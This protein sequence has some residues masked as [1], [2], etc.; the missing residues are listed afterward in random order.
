MRLKC[1]AFGAAILLTI[2]FR[3][4]L[5][6]ATSANA[7]FTTAFIVKG[8]TFS[9]FEVLN[10]VSNHDLPAG[11]D[12]QHWLSLQKTE[13]PSDVYVVNNSWKPVNFDGN[14]SVATTGWHTHPGHSLIVV[15]AGTLT[16]YEGEDCERH[17]YTAGD[18]LVDPGDGHVHILRNEGNVAASTVAVQIVPSDPGKANRRIDAPAP[19]SCAYI[20]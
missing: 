19:L 9:P 20:Q 7:G 15:T 3:A 1:G 4:T 12:G 10:N 8:A 14:N 11:F 17:I 6:H 5:V 16:E 2:V 18:T 13:G